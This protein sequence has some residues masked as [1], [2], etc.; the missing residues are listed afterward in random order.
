M[1][2]DYSKATLTSRDRVSAIVYPSVSLDFRVEPIQAPTLVHVME[3]NT[4]YHI[5]LGHL[6]LKAYK[7]VASIYHQCVKLSGGICRWSLRPLGCLLT[8]QCFILLS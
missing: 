4:S 1:R 3:G 8:K 6:W 7:A 2:K 5:I